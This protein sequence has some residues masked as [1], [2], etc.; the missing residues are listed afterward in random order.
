V[1]AAISGRIEDAAGIPVECRNVTVKSVETGATRVAT[2]DDG[3]N[4]KVLSLPLGPQEV[5][6]EKT[7]FKAAVRMGIDLKVGQEA[8]V[9]LHLEVGE[10]LQQ[11]TV[12]EEA[13]VVNT[14]TASVSG[15]VGEREV[16]DLPLNG[17]SFDN[18]I[19]LNAGAIN[20]SSMKSPQTSTSDGN[21][22]SVAGRLTAENLFLLNG[23][24]YTGS[25]QLAVSPGGVSG[26]LLGIDAVRGLTYSRACTRPGSMESEPARN[27]RGDAVRSNTPHGSIFVS[28]CET[29]SSMRETFS[30]RRLFRL[31]EETNSAALWAGL[32]KKISSSSLETTRGFRQ[33]LAINCVS[34]VPDQ[35]AR[36]GFLPNASGVLTEVPNLNRSMLQYM[37]FWP[38]P[39][40]PE[41]WRMGC[42]VAQRCRTTIP[43]NPF[44]EDFGT[45]RA[46][47]R[48]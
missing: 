39:N 11:V 23:V 6:A 1:T 19:T 13:P 42:P 28:S 20:Y 3:G 5:K 16:K 35:Q 40:G 17:R 21:T 31:S 10:L 15:V 32:S 30:I 45:V 33:S 47:T 43:N 4:F 22:F 41:L 46:D 7:G 8:V 2:T 29:A 26:D 9:N 37:S 18:L 36:Q 12:L 27:H 48:S 25:S 14:T 38:Q 44:R 34:V 24:E